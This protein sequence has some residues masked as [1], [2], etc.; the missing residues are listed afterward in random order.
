[1]KWTYIENKTPTDTSI[2]F[3]S[4][5]PTEHKI[6]AYRHHI[7]RM[8]S[9]PVMPHRKHKELATIKLL[10]QNNNFPQTLMEILNHQTKQKYTDK[11]QTN[12]KEQERKIWAT[13]IYYI[14][15]IRKITNIFKYTNVRAAFK[16]TKTL[17]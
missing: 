11:K 15:L 6:A 5:Q 4:N 7:N 2:N 3:S 1:M 13:L 8:H 12:S 14:P 17:Q 10:E 16:S 9:L